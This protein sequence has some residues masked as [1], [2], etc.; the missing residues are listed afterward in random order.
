[1]IEVESKFTISAE[2]L[3]ELLK[4]A[5]KISEQK[6][7]DQYFDCGLFSLMRKDIWLRRR[8]GIWEIKIPPNRESRQS[9]VKSY[10]E[11]QDLDL[12]EKTVM[13]CS[14]LSLS[15]VKCY[16]EINKFRQ[17]YRLEEFTLDLDL[18]DY[19]SSQY[20]VNEIELMAKNELERQD[21]LRKIRVFAEEKGLILGKVRGT[22]M[23]F[24]YRE[25]ADL[26]EELSLIRQ[27][28]M[29]KVV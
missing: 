3:A 25:K 12:I 21:A 9:E 4:Q 7:F 13:T 29:E 18:A 26:Y 1:M 24:L 23:E 10:L 16:A 27:G 22:L 15:Q 14:G 17:K 19:G 2:K 6:I 20:Q 8:Q 28:V 11:S 5:E